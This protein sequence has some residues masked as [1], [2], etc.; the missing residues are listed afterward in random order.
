MPYITVWI[1]AVWRTK[2][3]VPYLTDDIRGLV[4]DHIMQ[5]AIKKSIHIDCINGYLDHMHC[6]FAL[7]NDMSVAKVMNLIKGE[8]SFWIN[9]QQLCPTKFEWADEYYAGSVTEGHIGYVR[10]YISKQPEH[11]AGTFGEKYAKF[12]ESYKLRE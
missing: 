8:S 7:D 11:H 12:M 9:K 10:A 1:H 6:L 2:S 3:S 4:I 5:N